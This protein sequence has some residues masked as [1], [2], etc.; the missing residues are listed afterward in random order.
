MKGKR[1]VGICTLVLCASLLFA[2]CSFSDTMEKIIGP[3]KTM[4]NKPAAPTE[5][6]PV[7]PKQLDGNLERPV[8]LKDMSGSVDVVV[9][10]R[11][12]MEVQAE[13][14]DGGNVSYQWYRNNVASNGG[15]TLLDGVTSTSYEAD[16]SKGGTVYYYVVA[17]NT[18]DGKVNMSTSE[19]YEVTVWED[20]Y[21]QQNADLG[22]YQYMSRVDGK[23]PS[24]TTMTIDGTEYHFD[25][26]G[27][28]VNENGQYIDVQTGNVIELET[29]EEETPAPEA[30][31]APVEA[32]SEEEPAEEE[33]TEETAEEE[34]ADTAAE[35]E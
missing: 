9:G 13:V 4:E 32:V 29:S 10:A 31:E 27:F 30:T 23:F 8:F 11:T 1:T 14:H 5:G 20:M 6:I 7:E 17:A 2:G 18:K 25:E 15:G 35:G 22:A 28:A 16:T 19:V 33:Q 21:W 24:A 26:Q 3:V 34:T 12:V